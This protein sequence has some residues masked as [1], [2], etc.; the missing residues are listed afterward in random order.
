[1][2]RPGA[3]PSRRATDEAIDAFQQTLIG[4]AGEKLHWC[5][6]ARMVGSCRLELQTSCVSSRRS[7]QLSYEPELGSC[8]QREDV[9]D[10][11]KRLRPPRA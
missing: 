11:F 7:N 2:G 8:G 9:S 1:M 10:S 4:K 5:M 3:R 6:M